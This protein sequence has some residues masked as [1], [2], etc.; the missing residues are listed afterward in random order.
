MTLYYLHYFRI[1]LSGIPHHVT[2]WGNRRQGIV[3]ENDDYALYNDWL[4]QAC[5]SND[6]DVWSY[7]LMPNHVHLILVPSDGSGASVAVIL[8]RSMT[9]DHES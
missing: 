8:R 5:R 9:Q 4:A 3:M 7:C 1:V 6:V 2:H